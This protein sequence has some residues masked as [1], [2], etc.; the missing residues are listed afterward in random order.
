MPPRTPL[1]VIDGNRQP[2]A[3]LTPYQRGKIEGSCEAGSTFAFAADLV[4]CDPR[5][6]RSTVLLAPERP[7]GRTKDRPGRPRL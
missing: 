2:G 4:K 7:D 1:G 3:E 6:A 5:T